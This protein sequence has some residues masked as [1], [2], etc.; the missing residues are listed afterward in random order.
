MGKNVPTE[1]DRV[2]ILFGDWDEGIR[3]IFTSEALAESAQ[4]EYIANGGHPSEVRN[5]EDWTVNEGPY[6]GAYPPDSGPGT[7]HSPPI[8]E[9]G[10]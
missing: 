8:V 1:L 6:P 7:E 10:E 9:S 3:G 5:I 2:W 4:Q